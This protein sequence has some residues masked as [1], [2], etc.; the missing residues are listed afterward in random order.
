MSI[1]KM[2]LH[3]NGS[4]LGELGGQ[5]IQGALEL[6][7]IGNGED[8]QVCRHSGVPFLR[9]GVRMVFLRVVLCLLHGGEFLWGDG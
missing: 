8:V 7:V 1:S 4:Q 2:L 6:R 3:T 9:V 5:V